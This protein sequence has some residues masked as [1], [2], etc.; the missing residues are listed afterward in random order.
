MHLLWS[1][2]H[3]MW[4]L[5]SH[6]WLGWWSA[7]DH[8]NL[9]LHSLN[10]WLICSWCLNHRSWGLICWWPLLNWSRWWH[11]ASLLLINWLHWRSLLHKLLWWCLINWWLLLGIAHWLLNLLDGIWVVL[12]L[13]VW[14][15]N[16]GH[17]LRCFC[18]KLYDQGLVR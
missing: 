2:N 6:H 13:I 12:L 3:L 7:L 4:Y 18:L 1:L 8:W 5:L 16:V 9:L 11:H 14:T 10:R 17:I 15:G